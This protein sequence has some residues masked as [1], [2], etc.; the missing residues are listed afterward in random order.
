V[1][2]NWEL[3][4]RPTITELALVGIDDESDMKKSLAGSLRRR[5]TQ[6]APV[7]DN[8]RKLDPET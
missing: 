7:P 3:D 8:G 5:N 2:E 4:A 6:P 1:Q